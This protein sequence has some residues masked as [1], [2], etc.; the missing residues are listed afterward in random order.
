MFPEFLLL[1][2]AST[3]SSG[4]VTAISGKRVLGV[5]TLKHLKKEV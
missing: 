5:N 2:Q 4:T 3:T 1:L